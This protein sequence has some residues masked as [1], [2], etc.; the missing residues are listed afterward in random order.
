MKLNISKNEYQKIINKHKLKTPYLKNALEAF[1]SGGLIC[2]LGEL[3]YQLSNK[4]FNLE[5]QDLRTLMIITMIFLGTLLTG[6][7]I[8]DKLGQ[9]A[10]AGTIIPITG[11]SNSMTSSSMEYKQEGFVSGL[12]S[13]TFKLAG[14]VIVASVLTGFI[15]GILH[16]I[17]GVI[18]WKDIVKNIIMYI[19]MN[20]QQL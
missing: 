13:N 14:V 12:L 8:Y 18:F 7:G 9:K 19:L 2:A 6:F 4:L 15:L 5:E 11:F 20:P 17:W 10:K 1:F 3:I 16:Y